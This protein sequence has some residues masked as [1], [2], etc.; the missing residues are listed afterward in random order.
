MT[1]GMWS[2]VVAAAA[3]GLLTLARADAQI[4]RPGPGRPAGG[5]GFNSGLPQRSPGDLNGT[6]S[7]PTRLEPGLGTP[8]GTPTASS[9]GLPG[10]NA[11][12]SSDETVAE[13]P[14][15]E[16]PAEAVIDDYLAGHD[17]IGGLPA[18]EKARAIRPGGG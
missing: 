8:T 10:E 11:P 4:A 16:T 18:V 13:Q 3:V 17:L 14:V 1:P 6:R 7:P 12:G 5:G 15:D 2:L 9:G